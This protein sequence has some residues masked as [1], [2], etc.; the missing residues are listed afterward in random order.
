MNGRRLLGWALHA[1]FFAAWIQ[2]AL[3]MDGQMHDEPRPSAAEAGAA[4]GSA[5]LGPVGP[6][7]A[8]DPP[9]AARGAGP[10]DRAAL[11]RNARDLKARAG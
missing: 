2:V 11:A 7:A 8:S 10:A 4:L 9:R 1:A 6:A 5:P 3:V